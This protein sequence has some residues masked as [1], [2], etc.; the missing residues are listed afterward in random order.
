[1]DN[2]K[3]VKKRKEMLTEYRELISERFSLNKR[4]RMLQKEMNAWD[5]ALLN[6]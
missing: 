2:K 5:N 1:M 4:I 6:T 3:Y